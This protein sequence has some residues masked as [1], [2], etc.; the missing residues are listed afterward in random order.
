MME[1]LEAVEEDESSSIFHV[2]DGSIR[3]KKPFLIALYKR[4]LD[5]EHY[6]VRN[7]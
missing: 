1:Y 6:I 4:I 2:M 5:Q 7:C 3:L